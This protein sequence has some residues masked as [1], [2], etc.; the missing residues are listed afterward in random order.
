M[1]TV[2]R[3]SIVEFDTHMQR[4]VKAVST[5]AFKVDDSTKN[6]MESFS[7]IEQLKAKAVPLLK[8]GLQ[9]YYDQVDTTK[10]SEHPVETKVSI[11]VTYSPEVCT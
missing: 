3:D 8:K 4:I 10:H 6:I 2:G 5:I 1:R 9:T 11:M 7:D